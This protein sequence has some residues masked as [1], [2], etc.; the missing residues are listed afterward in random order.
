MKARRNDPCPCGSGKKY[1]HCCLRQDRIEES[2]E[3]SVSIEEATILQMIQEY[4]QA[5]RFAHDVGEAVNFYWGGAYNWQNAPDPDREDL[6]RMWEW[7]LHDYATGEDRRRVIDLFIEERGASLPADVQEVLQ[8]WSE[9][10]MGLF[11]VV[12]TIGG[13][14][15]RVYDPL[16]QEELE[17]EDASL[18]R[19]AQPDELL[20]GRLYTLDDVNR[21]SIMT[22]L[23]PEEYEPALV[24]YLTHAYDL[25]RDEHYQA[26]WDQFLRENGH[27]FSA[28]LF[29][30]KGEALRSLIGP[31]TR[32]HDPAITRDKLRE[33]T[34]RM[35]REARQQQME[36]ERR[37]RPPER[38]TSSGIILPGQEPEKEPEK[39][40]E[41]EKE[42]A[43]RRSTILIPGRDD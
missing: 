15:L 8:A 4:A 9:S 18:A 31:G 28:F 23:L 21:L 37:R 38:R 1:K 17:I 19:L 2:R 10:A 14:R 22:M 11:R 24:E 29:S 39:E 42:E 41:K 26:T 12:R 34:S 43:P 5:P 25:Y 16:R 20:I 27:L 13:Q 32:Y 40:K 35:D 30:A 33:H 7:F 3:L 6:R 36:Q